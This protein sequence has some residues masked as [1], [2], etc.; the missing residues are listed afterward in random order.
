VEILPKGTQADELGLLVNG[1]FAEER[2]DVEESVDELRASRL[3][4]V[5]RRIIKD[6]DECPQCR[7]NNDPRNVPVHP[8]CHCDVITDSI[9]AGVADSDSRFFNPLS[10]IDG[11]LKVEVMGGETLDAQAIQ[12]DPATTAILD[13][14]N[15]RWADLARWLEQ[16]Q[17]YL[18][19]G[20]QY[21]SIIVDDDTEEAIAQINETL[22][23]VAEDT[24]ELTEALQNRKLWFSIAKAVAF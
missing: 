17:P 13:A 6:S 4:S 9:E 2:E 16:M 23:V 15:V 24:E 1:V 5:E 7:A 19:A 18:N 14:E 10:L 3:S 12:L 22:E 21:V 11:D 8:N 20:E